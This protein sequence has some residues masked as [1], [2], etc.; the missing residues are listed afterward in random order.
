[1][2]WASI[3]M[4][5]AHK[6]VGIVRVFEDGTK[7]GEPYELLTVAVF[8]S[9]EECEI[10]G[11]DKPLTMPAG[12]AIKECLRVIGVKVFSMLRNGRKKT[13]RMRR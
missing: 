4:I 11:M 8:E 7:D 10:K 1:M 13:I 3:E 5:P 6:R 12:H 2:T 9:A